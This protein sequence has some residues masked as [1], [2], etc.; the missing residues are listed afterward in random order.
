M[1]GAAGLRINTYEET[2]ERS[3]LPSENWPFAARQYRRSLSPI[4]RTIPPRERLDEHDDVGVPFDRATACQRRSTELRRLICAQV[5][6]FVQ[7]PVERRSRGPQVVSRLQIQPEFGAGSEDFGQ[8]QRGVRRNAC[9]LARYPFDAR[10]RNA[11]GLGDL[12][13]WRPRGKRNS[14]RSISPGCI[15][16]KLATISTMISGSSMIVDDLDL[17]RPVDPPNKTDA[18][19]IVDP[20]RHSSCRSPPSACSR[21]PGGLRTSVES[22]LR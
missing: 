11:G 8:P 5:S 2:S 16:G 12:P 20:D 10:A 15:G 19:L 18:I 7:S 17:M 9:F 3:N 1:A 6:N 13:R 22:P 4:S 21:F 14:S